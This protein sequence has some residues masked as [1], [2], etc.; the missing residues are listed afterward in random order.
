MDHFIFFRA[1]SSYQ[2]EI[3]AQDKA[4]KNKSHKKE[5]HKKTCGANWK[6]FLSCTTWYEPEQFSCPQILPTTP[7]AP[8]KIE[9]STPNFGSFFFDLEFLSQI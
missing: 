9:W 1:G 8:I 5:P 2:K 3:P 4:T 7:P 6:N